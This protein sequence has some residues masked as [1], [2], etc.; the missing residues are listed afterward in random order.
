MAY[1]DNIALR[2]GMY[3]GWNY[4]ITADYVAGAEVDFGW[5]NETAVLHGSA[6]PRNLLLALPTFLS[7]LHH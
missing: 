7:E 3:G 4:Q 2:G 5:A 1:V 6:Y